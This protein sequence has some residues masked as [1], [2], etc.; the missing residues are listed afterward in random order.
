MRPS[1]HVPA[2]FEDLLARVRR[3]A[4]LAICDQPE[5]PCDPP[6]Q[7]EAARLELERALRHLRDCEE[8]LARELKNARHG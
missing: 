2:T 4:T 5:H 3:R 6:D 1:R 7:L 8:R